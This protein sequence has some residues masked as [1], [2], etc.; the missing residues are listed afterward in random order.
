MIFRS[1]Q[2]SKRLLRSYPNFQTSVARNSIM[3]TCREVKDMTSVEVKDWLDSFDTVMTD[4]DGV[5]WTGSEAIQGSPEMIQK[6]RELGKR[7]FYVT[8]N[9]TKHRRE[10]KTKVD[11]LGFG[12]DLE[13]IVGTAYLAAEYLV[14][15][16]FDKENKIVYVVGSSGITQELDDVGI[17]YLPIG[18]DVIPEEDGWSLETLKFQPVSLDPKVGAVIAGFDINISFKKILKGASYANVP[19]TMFVA[20]NTDEQFPMK[21]TG[22]II[23][24][25]GSMVAAVA[26]AAGRKPVVLGKPSKFMFEIVQARHP[27]IKPERTLMIG[28]RAN[29]DILLG[30]N[31]GLQTLL[32]GSGVHSLAETR[33]WETSQDAEERRMVADFYLDSLGDLL[34]KM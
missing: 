9:S 18:P 7:V 21:G 4:C 32:V 14:Q 23:P 1:L 5:L 17:K 15:Q 19:N 28:D 10:Y 24:G 2:I 33:Q 6:F 8:N 20:T 3:A 25:T 11:K 29:T 13:E 30:K 12:G 27:S 16:K 31:C 22:L 34:G 26:T